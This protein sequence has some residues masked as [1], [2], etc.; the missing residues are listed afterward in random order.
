MLAISIITR[1]VVRLSKVNKLGK[2][3]LVMLMIIVTT[4]QKTLR[5]H[6]ISETK[7][8]GKNQSFGSESAAQVWIRIQLGMD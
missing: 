7:R 1:L 3:M 8:T 6:K 5:Q 2:E 4:C